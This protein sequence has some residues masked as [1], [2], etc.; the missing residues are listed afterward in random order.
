MSESKSF[1]V[2]RARIEVE[3]MPWPSHI[4]DPDGDRE[5]A[6][7]RS[8]RRTAFWRVACLF[9]LAVLFSLGLLYVFRV[10]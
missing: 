10:L 6:L 3:R 1:N 9:T 4:A 5:R 2:S 7:R 8:Y